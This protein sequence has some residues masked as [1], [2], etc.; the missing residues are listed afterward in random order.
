MLSKHE[1]LFFAGVGT[2]GKDRASACGSVPAEE[3]FAQLH[4]DT[5]PTLFPLACRKLGDPDEAYDVVQE[6]FI[7]LWE[8]RNTLPLQNLS[9]AWLKKRLWF[10]LLSYFRHQGFKQRHMEH[11][12][13]FVETD[14]LSEKTEESD[15]NEFENDYELLMDAI[16]ITIAQ[17]PE[18]MR[19]VFLLNREQRFTINEI[20]VHLN[21]SPNT[22]RNH[23]QTAM[24]RLRSSLAAHSPSAFSYLWLCWLLMG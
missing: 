11:F 16:V 1:L 24:K 18:R 5:W 3:L 23:L 6:L 20:A 7:E 22:V 9:L 17:M 10:K 21:L 13:Y 15:R 8:K 4:G 12:R 14:A 19:E 2:T